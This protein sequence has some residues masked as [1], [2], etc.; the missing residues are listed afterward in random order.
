MTRFKQDRTAQIALAETAKLSEMRSDSF[1]TV[2]YVGGH[3]PMWDL[4]DNPDSIALPTGKRRR[5]RST[6]HV[7]CRFSSRTS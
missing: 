6:L 3:G 4:V 7:S 2:S 5:R 1:D